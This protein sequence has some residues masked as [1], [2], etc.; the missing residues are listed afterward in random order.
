MAKT[1]YICGHSGNVIKEALVRGV[2]DMTK[3]V[4]IWAGKI[5]VQRGDDVVKTTYACG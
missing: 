3:E 5:F 4:P 2:G 1:A